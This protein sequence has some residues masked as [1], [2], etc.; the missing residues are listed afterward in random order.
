MPTPAL[1]APRREPGIRGFAQAFLGYWRRRRAPRPGDRLAVA[2][3]I[4]RGDANDG[5][6]S[7]LGLRDQFVATGWKWNAA[8]L[9]LGSVVLLLTAYLWLSH[10]WDFEER[11][12]NLIADVLWAEQTLRF[13]LQADEDS[14]VALGQEAA[15]RQLT[16]AD[17]EHRVQQL[18]RNNPELLKATLLD[19]RGSIALMFPV[20]I[21]KEGARNL[22]FP[23]H[24]AET[25]D[26]ASRMGKPAYSEVYQG[27]NGDSRFMLVV[28]VFR[29]GAPAGRLICE[30][31]PEN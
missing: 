8:N 19:D 15:E 4:D 24:S 28:P 18:V 27:T 7:R 26:R 9:A 13:H 1:F 29:D 10:H 30:F 25:Q 14:I 22:S 16:A 5:I 20:S 31:S 21:D 12:R 11:R 6:D 3:G 23:E 2:G 17:F